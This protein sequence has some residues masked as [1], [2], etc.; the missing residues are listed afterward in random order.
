MAQKNNSSKGRLRYLDIARGICLISIVLGHLRVSG[1]NRIVFTYHLPIFYLLTGFFSR[2][3]D[4]KIHIKRK[5]RTL[6]VPYYVSVIFVMIAYS[7]V[8]LIRGLEKVTIL[9]RLVELLKAALYCAGDSWSEPFKI[10]SVGAIW[11]LWA[12][13]LGGVIFQLLLRLHP[14][15]RVVSTVALLYLADLTVKKL[16]FFPFSIQPACTAV[17]F[18]YCGYLYKQNQDNIQKISNEAKAFILILAGLVWISFINNFHSFWLVHSDI[19]RGIVDVIGS[20]AA[21]IVVIFISKLLDRNFFIINGLA[22]LGKNSI[23]FLCA[24]II[25]LVAF[26]Y[27][28]I[29]TK[30]LGEDPDPTTALYIKIIIKFVWIISFVVIASRIGFIRKLFGLKKNA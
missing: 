7:L 5:A 11:F 3:E 20:L 22:Y 30:F 4:F 26:P 18:I 15:I 14:G 19:G 12:L 6:I 16:F 13:F 2:K 28:L 29:I 17:F 1:I 27:A 25:E 24:H 8:G 10:Y 9:N 21:S 23:L